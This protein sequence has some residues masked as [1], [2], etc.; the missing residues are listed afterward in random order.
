MKSQDQTGCV[1]QPGFQQLLRRNRCT[2]DSRNGFPV[3][4]AELAAN[5]VPDVRDLRRKDMGGFL[6]YERK[7]EVRVTT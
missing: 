5:E 7:R 1:E 3:Q 2:A 4:S 6:R